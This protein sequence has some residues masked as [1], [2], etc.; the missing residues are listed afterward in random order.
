MYETV[1]HIHGE[2]CMYET[3]L[4]IHGESCIMQT[5][6]NQTR[7]MWWQ[8]QVERNAEYGGIGIINCRHLMFHR[9]HFYQ[10]IP[11]LSII[12]IYTQKKTNK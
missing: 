6:A 8:D 4:H 10:L 5:D 12:E 3:V 2:S 9:I 11:H 7:G 1:L